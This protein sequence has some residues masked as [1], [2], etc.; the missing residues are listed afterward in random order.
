MNK[1]QP[2]EFYYME[3][4]L[5]EHRLGL[6]IDV[7][8]TEACGFTERAIAIRLMNR[9]PRRTGRTLAGD[10]GY[11]AREFVAECCKMEVKPHVAQNIN[12]DGGSAIDARTTLDAG[13]LSS[14]CIRKRIQECFG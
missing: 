2:A 3:H 4:V 1:G 10:K 12:R 14:Q 9:Q 5:M 6:P 11:S 8:F 7:D 13:Y